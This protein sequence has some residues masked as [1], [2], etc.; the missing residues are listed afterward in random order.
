MGQLNTKTLTNSELNELFSLTNYDIVIVGSGVSCAYTIIH[1]ISLLSKQPSGIPV[2]AGVIDKSGEFWSGI[3]YGKRSGSHSLIISCLKEFLP[4]PELDNFKLWLSKNCNWIFDALKQKKEPLSNKWLDS[5]KSEISAGLWDELFIPRYTFGLYLHERL[6]KLLHEAKTQNIL[7]CSLLKADVVNIQRVKELYQVEITSPSKSSPFLT[8][9]KIILAIGSPPT[10][11]KWF[12]QPKVIEQPDFLAKDVCY[13]DNMYEPSQNFN[14]DLICKALKQSDTRNY[15]QVLIMG[16]NASALETIYSL[17]NSKQAC[18]L[19]N[20]FLIISPNAEFPHRI[21]LGDVSTTY[22]PK[23]LISLIQSQYPTAEQV[24]NAAK[25]DILSAIAQ[26]ETVDST[27]S[28]ISKAVIDAFNQLNSAEQKLFV[29]KYGVEIGKFQRRAGAD[30]LDVVEKLIQEGKLELLKG[31]FVRILSLPTEGGQGFEFVD[32]STQEKRI[33]TTPVRVVI[34]CA[35]FEDLTKSSSTLIK[36]L[37]RQGICTPNDSKN[38]FE[39]N[40]N[41]E[42]S[43]NFYLIGPLIAGNI[44]DKF[45][46]W[47]AESCA[48]II[49]ISQQLAEVLVQV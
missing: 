17:N 8:A 1:Y 18:D 45:K 5:Y 28:L 27:Y 34:N 20:K 47:H 13:I 22:N 26:N 10:K 38:G 40:E 6:D 43:Q 44:N 37:I 21:S 31:K 39:I 14:I 12:S 30:Y 4:E 48:R 36:N 24:F 7:E 9:Q 41:F 46:V 49:N 35:G 16:S 15:N 19:I 29:T 33:F 11:E 2:R 23:S 3:P 32:G 42:A 25:K